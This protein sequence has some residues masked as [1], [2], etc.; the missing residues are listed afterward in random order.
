MGLSLSNAADY[1]I[2]VA[3]NAVATRNEHAIICAKELIRNVHNTASN[4][5]AVCPYA[6]AQSWFIRAEDKF[7]EAINILEDKQ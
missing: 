4:L 7:S 2:S 5:R 6:E 1:L 3:I